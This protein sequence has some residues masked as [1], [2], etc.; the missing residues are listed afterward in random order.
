M[1]VVITLE[2]SRNHFVVPIKWVNGLHLGDVANYGVNCSV[3]HVVFLS[4]NEQ[5]AADFTLP[6]SKV[7][8]EGKDACYIAYINRYCGRCYQSKLLLKTIR[9]KFS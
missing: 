5:N 1:F 9:A 2:I 3:S 6:I 4:S 8:E 7:Y